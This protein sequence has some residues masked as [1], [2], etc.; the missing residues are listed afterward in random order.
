MT[1]TVNSLLTTNVTVYRTLYHALWLCWMN[2]NTLHSLYLL[3]ILWCAII[4]DGPKVNWSDG[5]GS[6]NM[7]HWQQIE[8]PIQTNTWRSN[9]ME[10]HCIICQLCQW[11]A[12]CQPTRQCLHWHSKC[13]KEVRNSNNVEKHSWENSLTGRLLPTTT[14][15]ANQDESQAI[16]AVEVGQFNLS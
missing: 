1:W 8:E 7:I 15:W 12:S 6:F 3:L 2:S 14:I 5:C 10:Q 11:P 16:C 9:I 4:T 13:P